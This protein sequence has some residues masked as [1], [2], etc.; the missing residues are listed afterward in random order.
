MATPYVWGGTGPMSGWDCSQFAHMVYK[1]FGLHPAGLD[2]TADGLWH[3]YRSWRTQLPQKAGLAFW[4]QQQGN[5]MVH[6]GIIS[7]ERFVANDSGLWRPEVFVI[8]A[9]GNR[10]CS[11]IEE[12]IKRGACVKERT[13]GF[14]RGIKLAAYVDPIGP[15]AYKL[16]Y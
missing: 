2:E 10:Q 6:V 9:S 3:R 15:F 4:Q 12:A 8:E 13:L 14:D 1:H 16:T 7:G 11:S 5:R